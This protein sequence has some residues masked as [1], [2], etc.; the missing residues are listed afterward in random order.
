M[1]VCNK[2]KVLWTIVKIMI[3]L[4]DS[5]MQKPKNTPKQSKAA[6]KIKLRLKVIFWKFDMPRRRYFIFILKEGPQKFNHF[7]Q[8][9]IL[10]TLL[11]AGE[12]TLKNRSRTYYRHVNRSFD[13]LCFSEKIR[14]NWCLQE[15]KRWVS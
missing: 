11:S 2:I 5:W 8:G 1:Y 9:Q 6:T 14:V 3:I 7:F 4:P 10:L 12:F 15:A 13:C